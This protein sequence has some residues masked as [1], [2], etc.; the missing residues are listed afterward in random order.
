MNFNIL[1]YSFYGFS[2]HKIYTNSAGLLFRLIE[3]NSSLINLIRELI[4]I[5]QYGAM[6]NKMTFSNINLS[7]KVLLIVVLLFLKVMIR[8]TLRCNIVSSEDLLKLNDQC[9]LIRKFSN[10]SQFY[11][12][13][14]YLFCFLI[15]HCIIYTSYSKCV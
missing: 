4:Y 10:F 11:L 9:H 13:F 15:L 3:S 1:I 6:F 7:K 2:F 12:F 8:K 5:F 14:I